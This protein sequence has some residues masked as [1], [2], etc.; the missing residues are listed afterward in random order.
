MHSKLIIIIFIF[1]LSCQGGSKLEAQKKDSGQPEWVEKRERMYPSLI[2]L[3][4]VGNGFS[5]QDAENDALNGISKIFNSTIDGSTQTIRKVNEDN[6]SIKKSL[7]LIR[8]IRVSTNTKLLNTDIKENYFNEEQGTHYALAVMDK[9]RTRVI[10]QERIREN[11][12]QVNNW[13]AAVSNSENQFEKLKYLGQSKELIDVNTLFAQM[14]KILGDIH[15]KAED[16]YTLQ[17][18]EKERNTILDKFIVEINVS[19]DFPKSVRNEIESQLNQFG[20]K[21]SSTNSNI[22][23]NCEYKEEQ[24]ELAGNDAKFI[25]YSFKVSFI[26]KTGNKEIASFEDSGR[27]GQLT[28]SAAKKKVEL[29]IKKN[30]EKNLINFINNDVLQ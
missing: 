20:F 16:K 23:V 28:L 30:I 1:L 27:S 22:L 25:N 29:K 10:Y 7:D 26:E 17:M 12:G 14:L 4:A 11:N 24:T 18:I 21:I 8:D 15:T 5:R 6:E 9:Q 19:E 13:M 2:Y 3:S